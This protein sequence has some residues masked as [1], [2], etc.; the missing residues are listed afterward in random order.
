M[1]TVLRTPQIVPS[2]F[3]QGLDRDDG[4]SRTPPLTHRVA[5]RW[6][7]LSGSWRRDADA[8][9]ARYVPALAASTSLLVIIGK[10]LL[11]AA[12]MAIGFNLHH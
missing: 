11:R 6:N 8:V 9:V 3:A 10:P 12:S 2:L 7:R 5:A 4:G 1:T